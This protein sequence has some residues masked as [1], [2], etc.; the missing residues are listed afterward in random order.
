MCHTVCLMLGLM[1]FL[2]YTWLHSMKSLK[3]GRI[4]DSLSSYG[5]PWGHGAWNTNAT[6]RA[7]SDCVHAFRYNSA[8]NEP[9]WMKSSARWLHCLGW[10]WQILCAIRAVAR[11]EEPARRNFVFF[12][13]VCVRYEQRTI[14][15]TWSQHVDRCRD[16]FYRNRI[17]KI[18]P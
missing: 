14:L 1:A 9:I 10:P 17:L 18:F 12:V 8:E 5:S 11:A 16:E 4:L 13:C 3:L 6:I 7:R 2:A 15:P